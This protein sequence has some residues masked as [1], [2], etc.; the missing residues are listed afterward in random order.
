MV[1]AMASLT[2]PLSGQ[3]TLPAA[4]ANQLATALSTNWHHA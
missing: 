3:T 2:P 4:T 1:Q